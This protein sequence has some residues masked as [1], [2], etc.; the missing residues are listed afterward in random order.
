M[1]VF[2]ILQKVY[3]ELNHLIMKKAFKIIG[4][5]VAFVAVILFI[6]GDK[7]V[8]RLLVSMQPQ[9]QWNTAEGEV[10]R[11]L[12]YGEGYRNT[13]DLYLPANAKP[14]ALMLFIHGGSWRSGKKEDMAWAAERY[15]G[16][17]YIT[18]SINY[19]RMHS[20]SMTYN[21]GYDYPCIQSMM[22]EIDASIK[23]I[24]SKC[25]ELGFNV[26]QMAVGGYSAGAHLAMLYSSLYAQSSPIPIKFQISWVGPSDFSLFFPESAHAK[27]MD[28]SSAVERDRI[29]EQ[30]NQFVYGVSD[31]KLDSQKP[32]AD[33]INALKCVI[34][35]VDNVDAKTPPAVLVYGGEDRLV[36]AA[37][38][39]KMSEVLNANGV[40]NQ[41]IIFPHSGHGLDSDPDYT[42]QVQQTILEFRD[43]YF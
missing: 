31:D 37:H 6:G 5:V 20:D 17:G 30:M 15:V 42:V 2:A 22:T 13:Y 35:P 3:Q 26:K 11:D 33:E 29:L 18:A 23:A 14:K 1:L 4:A 40:H 16:E 43:K 9:A 25:Q 12:S 8:Q 38:G 32:T 7:L 19:T 21:S 41:L 10:L 27:A 34:S 39:K 24:K 36:D 28:E